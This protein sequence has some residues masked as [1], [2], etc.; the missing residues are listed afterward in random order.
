M[1]TLVIP[2]QCNQCKHLWDKVIVVDN[3]FG[4][5]AFPDG[6]PDAIYSGEH[7][8]TQ[9]FDGDNGIRF[10]P[11]QKKDTDLEPTA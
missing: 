10:S 1:T 6:I 4:C 8:H 9:P 5:T 7:D 11:V 2:K 3:R